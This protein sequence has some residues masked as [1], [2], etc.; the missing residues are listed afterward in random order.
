MSTGSPAV[1]LGSTRRREE[2]LPPGAPF[3]KHLWRGWQKLARALGNLI[4]RVVTTIAYVV[5]VTPFAIGVRLFSDPL[6]IKHRPPRWTP[7]PPQPNNVD[8]A[9]RG[10]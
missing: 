4:S 3:Y 5:A 6:E 10:L 2:P 9:Q 8:E 7:I 1:Q